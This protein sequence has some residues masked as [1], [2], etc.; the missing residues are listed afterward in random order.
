MKPA[1]SGWWEATRECEN[2]QPHLIMI[3]L[4]CT[5]K[6]HSSEKWKSLVVLDEFK[7]SILFIKSAFFP[8]SW[9]MSV[10]P[11]VKNAT[12][13][14]FQSLAV[15]G[16]LSY[17]LLPLSSSSYWLTTYTSFQIQ[18]C[19]YTIFICVIIKRN[20]VL[21]EAVYS[22]SSNFISNHSWSS[23]YRYL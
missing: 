14:L 10:L 20:L 5:L 23:L 9:K 11:S 15:C 1:G 19:M 18:I 22:K 7:N 13:Q 6:L 2:S 8:L 3:L 17:S 16:L 12:Q 21:F 4:F